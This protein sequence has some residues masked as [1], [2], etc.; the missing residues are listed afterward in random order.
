MELV[1]THLVKT[2]DLGNGGN[3]FGGQLLYWI[4]ADAAAYAM[5]ICDTPKMVTIT[6][7]RCEFKKPAKEGQLLKIYCGIHNIGNTSITL[8]IEARSHNVYTGKQIVILNTNIKFI[9]VDN[10]GEAIPISDKVKKKY[11]GNN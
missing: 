10:E 5:Q 1:S 6:M 7:E 8:N 11:G 9:R 3:L 4:D 2:S